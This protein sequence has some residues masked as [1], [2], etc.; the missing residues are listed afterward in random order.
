MKKR[1]HYIKVM[2]SITGTWNAGALTE[3]TI[4]SQAAASSDYPALAA[5]VDVQTETFYD[6]Y[7]FSGATAKPFNATLFANVATG[8]HPALPTQSLML[9]NLPTG[10]RVKLFYPAGISGPAWLTT[11]NYY[12]NRERLIQTHSDNIL[13]GVDVLSTRYDFTG[14]VLGQL[15]RHQNPKPNANY[16]L[17]DIFK[18]SVYDADGRMLQLF[19]RVNTEP[20]RQLLAFEYNELGQVSRKVLGPGAGANGTNLESLNYTYNLQGQLTGINANYAQDRTVNHWWGTRLHYHDGY[21]RARNDGTMSGMQWRSRRRFDEAFSYGFEYDA[22]SRLQRAF[23]TTNTAANTTGGSWTQ[24]QDFTTDNLAYDENGNISSMRSNSTA[25]GTT[26]TV[27]N[28]SYTYNANSNLLRRVTDAGSGTP[29][30]A[31]APG[32][33]D[34]A[35]GLKDFKDGTNAGDDYTYD[36]NG[37]I[38]GDLNKQL[39]ITWNHLD[40]PERI[41]VQGSSTRDVRYV[42]DATGERLQKIVRHNDTIRTTTYIDGLTY[43]ND[44]TLLFF[45]HDGGR[46][47]R[48]HRGRLV[49]DFYIQDHLG[50]NRMV[51]TDERDTTA[52]LAAFETNRDVVETNTWRSRNSTREAIIN[53]SQLFN[54]PNPNLQVSRLNGGDAARRQGP[55]LVIKVMAGDTLNITTRALYNTQHG[56]IPPAGNPV[57]TMVQAAVAAFLGASTGT[58]DGK[59]WLQTGNNAVLNTTDL[60]S[61]LTTTQANNNNNIGPKAYLK[62]L[63]FDENFKLVQGIAERIDNGPDAV[64]TYTIPQ[65]VMQKNGFVYVYCS[66]ETAVNVLF[67]TTLPCCTAPDRCYRKVPFIHLAWRLP[68]LAAMP[69]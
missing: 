51:L 57:S 25:F 36:A 52:Y 32:F 65:Q 6:N 22:M 28:L 5:P 58:L 40:K 16:A 56:S 62:Y 69:P 53:T 37:N 64:H 38:T 2:P 59:S 45:E 4:R 3:A 33:I 41:V 7:T 30:S 55:S 18:R 48:N 43:L 35:T 17:L 12:D 10:T 15:Y 63:L 9:N 54:N 44:T 14:K 68:P 46:T 34:G 61:F 67:S 47:R 24:V 11:V 39:A 19:Q 21:T 60:G 42:Y 23:F 66:N 20:E 1:I 49:N 26:R 31:N 8:A 29:A 27:D 50:N 13:G